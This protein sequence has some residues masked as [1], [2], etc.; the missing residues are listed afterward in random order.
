MEQ[1]AYSP[2]PD[3]Q[4]ELSQM[5]DRYL[6]ELRVVTAEKLRELNWELK[7]RGRPAVP[8]GKGSPC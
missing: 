6:E 4:K 1:A 2:D 8:S 5:S 7:R 3:R